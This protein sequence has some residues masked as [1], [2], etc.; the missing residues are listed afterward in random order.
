MHAKSNSRTANEITATLKGPITVTYKRE[1]AEVYARALQFDLIGVGKSRK[2]ALNELR[3]IFA[4]YA[5]EALNTRG[6][7]RFFNPSD[8]DEWENPDK[9]LFSVVIVFSR[10]TK[11]LQFHSMFGSIQDLRPMRTALKAIQLQPSS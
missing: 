10:K 5:E 4:D 11:P 2:S 3:E 7:V 8:P 6:K 1:G 9:E